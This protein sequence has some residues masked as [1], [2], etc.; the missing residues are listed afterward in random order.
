M[1]RQRWWR[2]TRAEGRAA[3]PAKAPE[4]II[5]SPADLKARIPTQLRIT[6]PDYIVFV[7]EVTDAGVNDT[8][9]EHFLV[10]DEAQRAQLACAAGSR[11]PPPSSRRTCSAAP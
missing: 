9:N 3:A 4:P 8:G 6:K 1:R 5:A 2:R 10:F 7:P 11:R